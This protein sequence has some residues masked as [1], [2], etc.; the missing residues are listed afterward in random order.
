MSRPIRVEV[1]RKND[2]SVFALCGTVL[3]T[4]ISWSVNKSIWW[5]LFHGPI[6]GWFYV[7]YYACGY[8]R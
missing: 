1:T 6:C 7:V 8:G 4:I 3:A 5:A 2:V